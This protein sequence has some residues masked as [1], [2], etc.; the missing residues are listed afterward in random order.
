MRENT[1][2][3]LAVT[4]I[5]LCLAVSVFLFLRV[6]SPE[7]DQLKETMS[8]MKSAEADKSELEKYK[9]LAEKLASESTQMEAQITD[10][11]AVLPSSPETAEILATLDV[12][13]KQNGLVL[14][15]IDFTF[16]NAER[17]N[18]S[19]TTTDLPALINAQLTLRGNYLNFKTF[20]QEVEKEKR[21][22]NLFG[23]VI[24]N[25][26]VTATSIVV[27]NNK[28][29]VVTNGS[30]STVLEY[31]VSLTAYYQL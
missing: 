4:I 12:L 2:Q 17:Q 16:G 30:S 21:L 1:K 5:T 25:K 8:D 20:L 24:N 9:V 26:T 29:K 22:L 14:D 19:Q 7:R 23:L 31:Q 6:I 28:P 3:T 15:K 11:K 13:A 27:T 10:I 18:S